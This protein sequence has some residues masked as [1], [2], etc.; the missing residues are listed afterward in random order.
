M[1]RRALIL[2]AI[3]ALAGA[4][5]ATTFAASPR[6]EPLNM[7]T[8]KGSAENFGT[9][10]AGIELVNAKHTA[11]GTRAQAVLTKGQAAKLRAQGL[12]VKLVRNNKGQTVREQARLQALNGFTVWKSWDEAGG[13]R[14]QLY[15][16]RSTQSAAG[17]ARRPRPHLPGPRD[18]RAE[19][20]PGRPRRARRLAPGG[21]L[22][23]AP[24]RP[25]VDQRRGQPPHACATSSAGGG[26]TTRRSRT[27]SRRAS[28]GSSS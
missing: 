6:S 8:V 2:L 18:H 1:R 21:P 14:D 28:C 17:Q 12:A 4:L 27:C 24:A 25:R 7:Y 16:H 11:N 9:A 15:E 19:A 13:I 3:V 26:P 22:L 20:D 10:T 5:P 23:L